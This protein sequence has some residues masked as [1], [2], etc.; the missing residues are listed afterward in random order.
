MSTQLIVYPQNYQGVYNA[1]YSYYYAEFITNGQTFSGFNSTGVQDVSSP[2]MASVLAIQQEYAA[3]GYVTM[4][5]WYRWHTS[6]GIGVTTEPVLSGANI[7]F[8]ATPSGVSPTTGVFQLVTNLVVGVV[9]TVSVNT[10]LSASAPAILQTTIHQVPSGNTMGGGIFINNG[11]SFSFSFTAQNTM[12]ILALNYYSASTPLTVTSISLKPSLPVVTTTFS[13]GQV[14]CDLY[15]EEDIPLT[16]SIDEF[17]NVAEQVKSYSKDFNLPATKRNNQI[18]DNMFEI[19]RTARGT[20]FNPYVKTKCVLKQ[21]GFLLFEG[22]LRMTD[23]KDDEGEISYNVNLYSEVI[24]LADTLKNATFA[25]LDFSEL[26]HDYAISNIKNSWE[27]LGVGNGLLL[28]N[29]LPTS[30]FAYD[31]VTGINNTQVLKYPFINW[32]N[33]ISSLAALNNLEVA[34]R[35]CIQLKYLINK[36]FAGTE[37]EWS[38][39]FFETADFEKLF[40]DF[41]WGENEDGA[42]PEVSCNFLQEYDDSSG[43]FWIPSTLSGLKMQYNGSGSTCAAAEWDNTNY[44]MTSPVNNLLV[45]VE[46]N[47]TLFNPGTGS[48]GNTTKFCKF[49]AAGQ[50]LEIFYSDTTSISGGGTKSKTSTT[51]T[52]L[53]SGEYMQLISSSPTNNT[54]RMSGT[55][56]LSNRVDYHYGNHGSLASVLLNAQRGELG[57]WDFLKGLMTMFNLVSMKD[58]TTE[59]R[60]LIEPYSDVFIKNTAGTNLAS[61]GIEHDWTTKVDVSQME[62]MPLTELNKTTKFQFVEDEDDYAFNVYKEAT[63]GRLYGSLNYAALTSAQG[64][65]TMFVG[66]KEIT[67]EP[68]ASTVSKQL[69]SQLAFADFV[70]PVM[71]ARA[72][73][74]TCSAFE[75]SP[76]IFYNNGIISPSS[77]GFSVPAQN[78]EAAE[79][80]GYFLQFSHLSAIPA[81]S[82]DSDF[83]FASEQLLPGVATNIPVNNLYFTYWQP[84]FNELYNVDTRTMTMK[85]NL[86]PSDVADFDFSDNVFIKNRTFRVNKI[87]YKPNS[88]ATVEFILLP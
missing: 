63:S 77:T 32:T 15:E 4:N 72:E 48:R 81:T 26:E 5:A 20:T 74:G 88:L 79:T 75:N 1:S 49:N 28:T 27:S 9:Y 69:N 29:P 53:Q 25:D 78:Y 36:I 85:V 39:A 62:L 87:E 55:G 60:I 7:V 10:N 46:W 34:F 76:R 33:Q 71:Y 65:P 68:F 42:A 47:F 16:L 17:K 8:P 84:Y 40:M 51:Q 50:V 64:L 31:A 11:T 14:I 61:R 59:N 70:T 80:V 56:G 52:Y 21:D 45:T 19:T 67:A 23:I 57:Q 43:D 13:D 54:V 58:P 38:S 86:S 24:A 83:V 41:N 12:H 66:E 37:F 6:G 35:P 30:S 82:S 44:K 3:T 18:F 2:G 73:D 22:F